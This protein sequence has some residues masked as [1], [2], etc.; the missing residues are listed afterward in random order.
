MGGHKP[1]AHPSR[2]IDGLD[3][4]EPVGRLLAGARRL[5]PSPQTAEGISEV[6]RL[7][8]REID[9]AVREGE[10]ADGVTLGAL[11]IYERWARAARRRPDSAS[12]HP[13]AQAAP[14][15]RVER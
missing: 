6:R 1:V 10:I 5:R 11:S 13:G 8:R 4:L 15:H 2:Q 9:A 7:S 3:A 12:R 14:R